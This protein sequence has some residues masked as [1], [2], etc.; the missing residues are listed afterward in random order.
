M[1]WIDC[2]FDGSHFSGSSKD[3]AKRHFEAHVQQVHQNATVWDIYF[4]DNCHQ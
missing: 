4:A 1:A 3:E 2:P